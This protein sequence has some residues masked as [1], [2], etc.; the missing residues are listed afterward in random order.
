MKTHYE[1]V[2][3]EEMKKE[4]NYEN[5]MQIPRIEKIVLNMGVGEAVNDKKKV[6]SAAKDLAM[7][8]G[9]RAVVTRVAQVDRHLQV[10]RGHADRCQ[11]DAARR[12]HVRVR[13]SARY[14]RA[15][16]REGFPRSQPQELRWERQLLDGVARTHRV[17][18]DRLRPGRRGVGHGC[19]RLHD[20][21]D[22]TTRR[23]L[24][25]AG[26]ISRFAKRKR[27]ALED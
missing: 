25:C 24:C 5:V 21:Q 2:V 14:D 19:D 16:A 13:G 10:A 17:S 18:G 27:T 23:A 6:D 3:R 11:G 22:P 12:P 1:K 9:Q 4:F 8:A 20:R 15:A 26:S 7:I